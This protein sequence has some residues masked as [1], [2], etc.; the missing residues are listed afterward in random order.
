MRPAWSAAVL[1]ACV[2]ASPGA[3][4][5]RDSTRVASPPAPRPETRPAP[6]SARTSDA[7]FG[8]DKLRHFALAGMAQGTAFGVAT[9]AGARGR[10]ALVSASAAAAV[11]SLGKELVDRRRGGRFSVR[12]LAWDAAGAALCGVLLARSGR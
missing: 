3:Q 6:P 12:D 4:A 7:W 5:P 11:L 1:I 10:P 8:S 9:A 2:A